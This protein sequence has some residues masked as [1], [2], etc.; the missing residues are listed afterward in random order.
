MH[1]TVI[2]ASMK[3]SWEGKKNCTACAAAV[4][5]SEYGLYGRSSRVAITVPMNV[6]ASLL[7][8]IVELM[9]ASDAGRSGALKYE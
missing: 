5:L 6:P 7:T 3:P 8:A 9:A 1:A 4:S 2:V